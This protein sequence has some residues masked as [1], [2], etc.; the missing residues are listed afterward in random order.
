VT[1]QRDRLN[2][3][4]IQ[5]TQNVLWGDMDAFQHVNN[6]VYFRYFE[7]ARV[8][9]MLRTGMQALFDRSR[10]GPILAAT[11]CDYRAPLTYP[12]TICIGSR[13]SDIQARK[14]SSE[15]LVWSEQHDKIVAEGTGL[16]VYYD[17]NAGKTCA[18]PEKIVTAIER[19]SSK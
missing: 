14:I 4:P 18:V 3:Y 2:T 5:L 13:V 7:D 8:D 16:M 1:N 12:D 15:Y 17:Y 10:I 11:S 6:T 19:L 9:F